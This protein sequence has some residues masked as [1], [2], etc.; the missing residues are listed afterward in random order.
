[1]GNQRV[2]KASRVARRHNKFPQ[3]CA[4]RP[5]EFWRPARSAARRCNSICGP[6]NARKVSGRDLFA[7]L[8]EIQATCNDVGFCA[9]WR[10]FLTCKCDSICAETNCDCLRGAKVDKNLCGAVSR[11]N[12]VRHAADWRGNLL[13]AKAEQRSLFSPVTWESCR[14]PLQLHR[15]EVWRLLAVY[16][17]CGSEASRLLCRK[18]STRQ[19]I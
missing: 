16:N 15:V 10:I 3:I 6:A 18:R 1:M 14:Q 8:G 13:S 5:V 9:I 17:R 19:P 12:L 4:W 7:K 2:E 11:L